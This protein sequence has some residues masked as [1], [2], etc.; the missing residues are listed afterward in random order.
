MKI[1]VWH[2]IERRIIDA[3]LYQ[4]AFMTQNTAFLPKADILNTQRKSVFVKKTKKQHCEHL[5]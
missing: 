3:S 2:I 1:N 5:Q 4:V